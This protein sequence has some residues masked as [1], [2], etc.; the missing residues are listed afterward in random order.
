MVN[1]ILKYG[2]NK[3]IVPDVKPHPPY[4]TERCE[5]NEKQ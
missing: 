4:C 5:M 3:G 2:V 1:I